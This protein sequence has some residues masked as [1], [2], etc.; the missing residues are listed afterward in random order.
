L[1]GSGWECQRT[2][3]PTPVQQPLWAVAAVCHL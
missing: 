2:R 1:G 3:E